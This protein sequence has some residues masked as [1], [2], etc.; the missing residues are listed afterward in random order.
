MNKEIMILHL[1][2]KDLA[3]FLSFVYLQK[4]QEPTMC[5]APFKILIKHH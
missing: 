3:Q 1:N 4:Y 2:A 5:K